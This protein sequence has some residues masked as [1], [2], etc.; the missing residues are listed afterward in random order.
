MLK[1]SFSQSLH[2]IWWQ[3][4]LSATAS[5]MFREEGKSGELGEEETV[6]KVGKRGTGRGKRE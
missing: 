4:E 6:R 1:S 3:A 5:E 2:T